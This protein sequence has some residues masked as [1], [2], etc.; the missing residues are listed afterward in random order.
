M[1]S[2]VPQITEAGVQVSSSSPQE[3][4]QNRTLDRVPCPIVE[5]IRAVPVPQFRRSIV[6]M[7][8]FA[9]LERQRVV[10]SIGGAP[11][12]KIKEDAVGGMHVVPQEPRKKRVFLD[13]PRGPAEQPITGTVQ[14]TGKVFTVE[15]PHQHV[16]QAFPGDYVVSNIKGLDKYNLRRFGD[17]MVPTLPIV[18]P[19]PQIIEE[20]FERPEI[21]ERILDRFGWSMSSSCRSSTV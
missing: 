2:P 20:L 1:D 17:V 21:L 5:Q 14:C 8:Q 7:T 4:V 15:M 13:L 9:P 16:H 18:V 12:P 10:D 3:R 19:V 11:V 6:E